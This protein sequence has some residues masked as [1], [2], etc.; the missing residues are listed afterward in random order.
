MLTVCPRNTTSNIDRHHC[1]QAPDCR[2]LRKATRLALGGLD[3]KVTTGSEHDENGC[4]KPS[5]SDCQS[6]LST[7]KHMCI[8]VLGKRLPE[9]SSHSEPDIRGLFF[10]IVIIFILDQCI[11]TSFALLLPLD[12][13]RNSI[14]KMFNPIILITTTIRLLSARFCSRATCS[15]TFWVT[16][17]IIPSTMMT[18]RSTTNLRNSVSSR[19]I[20]INRG[21]AMKNFQER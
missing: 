20:Q 10:V 14:G 2:F 6:V 8:N 4:G 11:L 16:L 21:D 17:D 9:P 7:F 18:R 5:I 1:C 19:G 12:R 13:L 3:L 15:F